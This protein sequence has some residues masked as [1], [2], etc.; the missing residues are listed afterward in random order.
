VTE[1]LPIDSW[2]EMVVPLIV[3]FMELAQATENIIREPSVELMGSFK[4]TVDDLWWESVIDKA[5]HLK[6]EYWTRARYHE[7]ARRTIGNAFTPSMAQKRLPKGISTFEEL[8]LAFGLELYA[9][10]MGFL[11]AGVAEQCKKA[12]LASVSLE[13]AEVISTR[14]KG[15]VPKPREVSQGK[16]KGAMILEDSTHR[17]DRKWPDSGEDS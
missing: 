4:K 7:R 12:R 17:S 13:A 6:T 2:H 8:C 5:G 3:D 15:G 9:A 1:G 11:P 10:E 14:V 16:E